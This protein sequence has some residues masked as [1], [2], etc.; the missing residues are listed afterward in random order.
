MYVLVEV[1]QQYAP[2]VSDACLDSAVQLC[3]QRH[4]SRLDLSERAALLIDVQDTALEIYP[5]LNAAQHLVGRAEHTI[6]QPELLV[7]QL[8]QPLVGGLAVS[9]THLTLPT[10]Y[11]A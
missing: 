3:P 7:E 4:E 10:I 8:V 9:Y 6:E 2:R 11:S 1:L 5:R